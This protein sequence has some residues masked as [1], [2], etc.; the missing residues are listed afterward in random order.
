MKNR[1]FKKVLLGFCIL[2]CVGWGSFFI[3]DLLY[4]V[5][6]EYETQTGVVLSQDNT[7]L[8]S[9]A[10]ENG[11]WRYPTSIDKV[12]PNYIEA[13][14]GYEDRWFYYHPGVNPFS[15]FR[16]FFQY[17][18]NGYIVSG[19]STLTMQVARLKRSISR[20]CNGKVIQIFTAFQLEWH[21][22]KKEILNYYI[23]HA[24]FGG[25]Q[26]GVQAASYAYFEHGAE[27]LTHAQAALLAVMPQAPTRYR[28]DLHSKVAEKARN[29][30]LDRLEK[31]KIWSEETI[32]EYLKKPRAFIKG[33]KMTFPGIK[34]SKADEQIADLLAYIKQ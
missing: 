32:A 6:L 18:K 16:A 7:L 15:L 30:L 9:F 24:P 23:N 25:V 4:P 5:N 10:D 13:L 34:G 33:T 2:L 29:K 27:N 22:S 14:I 28:P 1:L 20:T 19:G 17:L 26:Q 11:V 31:F 8:R 21:F 3:I 12:S